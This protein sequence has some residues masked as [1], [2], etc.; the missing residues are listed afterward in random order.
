MSTAKKRKH[1]VKAVA[2]CR[3]ICWSLKANGKIRPEVCPECG[4]RGV[5]PPSMGRAEWTRTGIGDEVV[6]VRLCWRCDAEAEY[7]GYCEAHYCQHEQEMAENELEQ[8]DE[9]L[10]DAYSAEELERAQRLEE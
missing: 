7:A 3:L 9:W 8:W 1:K 10:E 4:K 5:K 6:C 2:M